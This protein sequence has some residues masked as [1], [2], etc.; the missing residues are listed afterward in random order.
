MPDLNPPSFIGRRVLV[1]VPQRSK[2]DN[3]GATFGGSWEC[4]I[5]KTASPL[6]KNLF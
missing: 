6:I 1:G 4:N 3:S 2:F 5:A